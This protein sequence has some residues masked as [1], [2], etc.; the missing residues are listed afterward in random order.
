M[1][2]KRQLLLCPEDFTAYRAKQRVAEGKCSVQKEK[3]K[4]KLR[5]REKA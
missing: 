5:Q 3:K 2:H 4:C 1:Y